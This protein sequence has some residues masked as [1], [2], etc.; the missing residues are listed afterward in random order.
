MTK[1]RYDSAANRDNN[2]GK[3]VGGFMDVDAVLNHD[4]KA[5]FGFAKSVRNDPPMRQVPRL[6][7]YTIEFDPCVHVRDSPVAKMRSWDA[8]CAGVRMCS[9][10]S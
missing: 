3:E 2:L 4:V 10:V 7:R 5:G 6:Y 9:S 8:T 1:S